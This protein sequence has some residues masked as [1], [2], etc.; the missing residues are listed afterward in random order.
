MA[1]LTAQKA[2]K[3]LKDGKVHGKPLS[4]DQKKFFG[5]VAGEGDIIKR[6]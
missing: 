1:K 4:P 3:I 5:F 6:E 2:K